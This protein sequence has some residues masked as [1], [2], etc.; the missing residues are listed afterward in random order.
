VIRPHGI[1]GEVVVEATTDAPERYAP[2]AVLFVGDP[3]GEPS[4][5]RVDASRPHKGR[6]LV[7]FQGVADRNDAELLRGA[8]LS[9]DASDA[10]TPD[11]GRYYAHQ[12]EGLD[13]VDEAG[14]KLGVMT[15]VLENPA[16]DIWIVHTG[17]RDVLVPA[18]REIVAGVDLG[19]RR[20]VL[21]PIP[22][23]FD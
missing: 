1:R 5:R 23:L 19:A 6:M 20:I 13:V 18:V 11:R 16:N 3:S 21:R 10:R 14:A 22:G 8:L 17:T 15:G 4:P 2:G 9:I 7:L 12:L